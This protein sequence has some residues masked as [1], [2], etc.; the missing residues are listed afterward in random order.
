MGDSSVQV[1]RVCK[2]TM[3]AMVVK[4]ITIMK[5]LSWK[6]SPWPTRNKLSSNG[7]NNKLNNNIL[8]TTTTIPI[9]TLPHK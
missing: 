8:A 2:M 6:N 4:S 7:N 3:M 9:H 1:I 5:L